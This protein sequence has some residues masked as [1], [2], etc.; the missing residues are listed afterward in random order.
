VLT[1]LSS[2]RLFGFDL[3]FGND[4]SVYSGQSNRLCQQ[5]IR[6]PS[7]S[8]TDLW[9]N[10]TSCGG[11][12]GRYLYIHLSGSTRI[13]SL[14]EVQAFGVCQASGYSGQLCTTDINECTL[15]PS[16]CDVLT[17]CINSVGSFSCTPCPS[18]YSGTGVTAC[19]DINEVGSTTTSGTNV[20]IVCRLLTLCRGDALTDSAAR[21]TADVTA[22]A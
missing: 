20:F 13:L 22:R 7:G 16:P 8:L 3:W 11:A 18:G 17:V 15:N 5:V 21:T 19:V 1:H 14:C 9:V 12:G 2:D 6:P 10:T 4:A